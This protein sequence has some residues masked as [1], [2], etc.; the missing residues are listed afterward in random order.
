MA[1]VE[2]RENGI[3]GIVAEV[4]AVAGWRWWEAIYGREA[5]GWDEGKED[6]SRW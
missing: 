2:N 1:E 6:A 3:D 5:A 4:A